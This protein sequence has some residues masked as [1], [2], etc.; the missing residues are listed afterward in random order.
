MHVVDNWKIAISYNGYSSLSTNQTKLYFLAFVLNVFLVGLVAGYFL[1]HSL[2]FTKNW[3]NGKLWKLHCICG[4]YFVFRYCVLITESAE[5]VFYIVL[6]LAGDAGGCSFCICCIV[7]WFHE[8]YSRTPYPSFQPAF[9][10]D[11]G[12]FTGLYVATVLVWKINVADA[13]L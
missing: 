7:E 3:Q 12:W 8:S 1:S 10:R 5:L 11:T 9:R 2:S 13:L 4:A 6:R